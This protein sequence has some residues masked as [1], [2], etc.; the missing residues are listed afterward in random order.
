MSSQYKLLLF[1]SVLDN[2]GVNHSGGSNYPL[3]G[4]KGGYF[5]GGVK[6]VAFV[7][8]FLLPNP[9]TSSFELMHI[10]DWF[11]TLVTLGE[12]S[13]EDVEL[14]GFDIWDAIT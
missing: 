8:S 3:R 13:L 2:G 4:H 9:G 11:P 6:A 12:G 5:E 7:H 1:L 14:D 10:S